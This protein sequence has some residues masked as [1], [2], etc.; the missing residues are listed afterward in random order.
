VE[1][2]YKDGDHLKKKLIRNTMKNIEQQ[3]KSYSNFIRCH[4][5]CIVN[6]YYVEKLD[7]KYNSHWLT[8]K[9]YQEQLPVSRQYL[10]KLKDAI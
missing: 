5:I 6:T 10:L 8:I 4:R 3:I 1:I 7:R 9:G 2:V